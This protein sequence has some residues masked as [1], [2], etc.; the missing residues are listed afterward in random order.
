VLT[1]VVIGVV[2]VV[3][4]GLV[5]PLLDLVV[6]VLEAKTRCGKLGVATQGLGWLALV[7][8]LL[9]VID[10]MMGE[11]SMDLQSGVGEEMCMCEYG[12]WVWVCARMLG[13]LKE[14]WPHPE[15]ARLG[16]GR[17]AYLFRF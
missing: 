16:M 7:L 14:R 6:F 9:L 3:T 15:K 10:S 13:S 17:L 11:L 4:I 5:F 2:L 8:P 1:A 12:V